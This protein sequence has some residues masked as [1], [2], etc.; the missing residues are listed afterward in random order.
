M[1]KQ[2]IKETNAQFAKNL[3]LY[4][5]LANLSQSE[6]AKLCEISQPRYN[7]YEAGKNMPTPVYLIKMAQVL[8][9]TVEALFANTAVHNIPVA[10]ADY[11]IAV[12][13]SLQ[14]DAIGQKSIGFLAAISAIFQKFSTF[15][16][17]IKKF[18]EIC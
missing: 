17:T 16:G 9:V 1:D 7:L 5:T 11:C 14:I 12:L 18:W 10:N 15:Y 4:R 13:A 3:Q 8:G 6:M 2:I